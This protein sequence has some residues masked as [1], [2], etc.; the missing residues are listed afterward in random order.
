M[1][2][3]QDACDLIRSDVWF[4]DGTVVLQADNTVFRVYAGLLSR[5]SAYFNDLFSA[6]RPANT[7]SYEGCLL[8]IMRGD[9]SA[10]VRNFLLAMLDVE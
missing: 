2:T 7:D 6:P 4:E 5:H 1:S 9:S 3:R 8:I 10:A